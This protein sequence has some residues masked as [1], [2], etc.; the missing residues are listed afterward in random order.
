MSEAMFERKARNHNNKKSKQ[1]VDGFYR[2]AK[3]NYKKRKA[4]AA[5]KNY[6]DYE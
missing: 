4:K 2:K 5:N 6:S 3:A 1:R